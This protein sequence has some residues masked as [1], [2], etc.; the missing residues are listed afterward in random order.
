MG[1]CEL[2]LC[3][4]SKT[5]KDICCLDCESLKLC[6]EKKYT[7]IQATTYCDSKYCD[8]YIEDKI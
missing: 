4:V 8:K 6:L 7:C 2:G 3:P 5:L 1:K